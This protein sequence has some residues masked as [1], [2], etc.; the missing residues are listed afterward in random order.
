MKRKYK[1]MNVICIQ[2]D[3][4]QIKK[5]I[6]K[7]YLFNLLL[8]FIFYNNLNKEKISHGGK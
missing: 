1:D 4:Y 8:I 7:L 6:K 5:K 3:G 2:T